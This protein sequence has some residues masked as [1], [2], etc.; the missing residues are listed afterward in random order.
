LFLQPVLGFAVTPLLIIVISLQ[1][2]IFFS[3]P[4]L[5]FAFDAN[6]L[7]LKLTKKDALRQTKGQSLGYSGTAIAAGFSGPSSSSK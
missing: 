7:H 2:D 5:A 4:Q 6:C 3:C 1:D